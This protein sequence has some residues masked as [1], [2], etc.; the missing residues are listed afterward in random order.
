MPEVFSSITRRYL[1]K[2]HQFRTVVQGSIA[3][4]GEWMLDLELQAFYGTQGSAGALSGVVLELEGLL[5]CGGKQ[6]VLRI[7]QQTSASGENLSG[8]VAAHQRVIDA[9]LNELPADIVEA[10]TPVIRN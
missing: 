6:H 1:S 5:R 7:A 3:R 8:L 4:P 9:A 10:C 2:S